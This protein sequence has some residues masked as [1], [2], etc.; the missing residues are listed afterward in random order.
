MNRRFS[1]KCPWNHIRWLLTIV[2]P[3]DSMVE[4]MTSTKI[5]ESVSGSWP[6]IC[7]FIWIYFGEQVSNQFLLISFDWIC[8]EYVMEMRLHWNSFNWKIF[9]WP[10]LNAITMTTFCRQCTSSKRPLILAIAMDMDMAMAMAIDQHK[11]QI[12]HINFRAY[13]LNAN[14]TWRSI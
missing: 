6:L 1:T 13:R 4:Q 5:T 12:G 11:T 3:N 2:Y 8:D 9:L 7:E 14:R 10:T